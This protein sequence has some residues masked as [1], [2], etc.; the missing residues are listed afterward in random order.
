VY[1]IFDFEYLEILRLQF[2]HDIRLSVIAHGFG[3]RSLVCFNQCDVGR[4][5]SVHEHAVELQVDEPLQPG[6][7][8]DPDQLELEVQVAHHHEVAQARLEH[9]PRVE[10]LRAFL[11]RAEDFVAVLAQFFVELD[12]VGSESVL[13]HLALDELGEQP[14]AL[15]VA[16]FE[17]LE[18]GHFALEPLVVQ[19]HVPGV[20]LQHDYV[21]EVDLTLLAIWL[22][23]TPVL[24][25]V[26]KVFDDEEA[27]WLGPEQL[28][29]VDDLGQIVLG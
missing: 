21:F 25:E 1:E 8:L 23:Q 28:Q 22:E 14:F 27:L 12:Q 11:E 29:I 17:H 16:H 18:R 26:P 2:R 6:L 24:Q 7:G 5:Y 20:A 19:L 13:H 15:R 3:D 9:L 10:L 4:V